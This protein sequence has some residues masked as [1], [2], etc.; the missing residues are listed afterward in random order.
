[1][2]GASQSLLIAQ[3]LARPTGDAVL[4]QLATAASA[5]QSASGHDRTRTWRGGIM[6][7]GSFFDA[8]APLASGDDVPAHDCAHPSDNLR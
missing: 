7:F 2:R 6:A 4:V 3:V 8:I 1:M 5:T